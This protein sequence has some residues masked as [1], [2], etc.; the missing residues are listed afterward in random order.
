MKTRTYKLI[1]KIDNGVC[2]RYAVRPL[3][4]AELPTPFIQAYELTEQ[5]QNPHPVYRVLLAADGVLNCTCPAWQKTERC[6]HADCLRVAGLLDVDLALLVQSRTDLLDAAEGEAASLRLALSA[7]Q[8][9]AKQLENELLSVSAQLT[10]MKKEMESLQAPK[11][12]T[13]R[14]AA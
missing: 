13:R 8:A 11:R 7:A 2:R 5:T 1:L 9:E 3:R 4:P 10:V 12:R 6:K 14:N